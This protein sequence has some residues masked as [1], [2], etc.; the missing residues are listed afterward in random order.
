[1][2]SAV[3]SPDLHLAIKH[4]LPADTSIF[5]AEAWAILQALIL[6]ESSSSRKAAVFSD[7]KSA[8]DALASSSAKSCSNYLIPMIR[9]KFHNMRDGYQISLAWVPSYLEI[10][11]NEKADLLARQAA[12]EGHKTKFKIPATDL[13][14]RSQRSFKDKFLALLE[15]DFRYKGT[16][17]HTHFFKSILPIKPWFSHIPLPRDQI[18]IINRLRSNHYNLNLSLYRKNIINSP[19]CQCGDPRQDVNH[20]IFRCP[21]TRNKSQKLILYLQRLDPNNR[22]NLFPLIDSLSPKLCRLLASF[23]KSRSSHLIRISC[24]P[25][26]LR[27]PPPLSHWCSVSATYS[28]HDSCRPLLRLICCA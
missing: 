3:F 19:L 23:F 14:L 2:G 1:V 7:S 11:G 26:R 25:A 18:V 28:K 22:C 24:L 8:L 15:N 4:R 20:V 21:L 17:Y 9:S 6:L 16:L 27:S 10:W 13:F 12:S 5:S